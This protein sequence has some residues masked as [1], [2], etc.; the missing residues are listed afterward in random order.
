MSAIACNFAL[1]SVF[2]AKHDVTWSFQYSLCGPPEATGGFT[3]FLFDGETTTLAGG[4]I[5]TGLAYGPS[6]T[7]GVVDAIMGIGFDSTGLFATTGVGYSTGVDQPSANTAT[8]RTGTGFDYQGSI[9]L[10]FDVVDSIEVFKTLRF[11]L[12]DVGQTLRV[13]LYDDDAKTYNL[14]GS[15]STGYV[16][17]TDKPVRIGVSV[18]TPVSGDAGCV[19]KIK[20]LHHQGVLFV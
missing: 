3:T 19:F 1:L 8:L 14:I 6:T 5:S 11:N 16:Y 2:D 13:H 10:P 20:D 9:S 4:G 7:S 17:T 18:A 12:T 15:L